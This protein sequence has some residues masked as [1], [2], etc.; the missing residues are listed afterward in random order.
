[1]KQLSPLAEKLF[2]K[3]NKFSH[4][5]SIE[6]AAY[7]LSVDQTISASRRLAYNEVYEYCRNN[8]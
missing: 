5:L 8:Y 3:L 2:D 4:I 6:M 1:M 7:A